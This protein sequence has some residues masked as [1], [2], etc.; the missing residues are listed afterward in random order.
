MFEHH[1]AVMLLIN[2]ETGHI[3]KANKSAANYYGYSIQEFEEMEIGKINQLQP[4]CIRQTI[5]QMMTEECREFSFQHRLKNGEIRYV[6]VHSSPIIFK[7]K[8]LLFS[9]IHDITDRKRAEEA[10]LNSERH[11]NRII[12]CV[13]VML[14]DYILYPDGS[15]RFLY[16]GPSCREILELDEKE[17]L[18]DMNLFWKM[19]HSD[20][21][22]RL[23]DEDAASNRE[24]KFFDT[25]VRILTQSGCFKWIQLS[26]RPNPAP[27]GEPAIWSGFILDVTERRRM[28]E[29]LKEAK[30]AAES[31][32]RAKSEF[33]ANMSHEIRTPMNVIIGM[34]RLIRETTLT[35]EQQEYALILSHSSEIL[36]SLIEDILDFS[37]IEAGKIELESVDFDLKNFLGKI[38]DILKIKASEKGLTLSCNISP[39]IPRFLKGDRN[40]LRQVILNLL[41]NSVKF[42]AKGGITITVENENTNEQNQIILSFSVADTGIGIPQDRLD[43]MFQPF[44]QADSSTTRKYGGTGL[45][46][47]IS[48]RLVELMGGRIL[49][50]SEYGKGTT[51]RFT[52]KFEQGSKTLDPVCTLNNTTLISDSQFAGLRVLLA[53]DN[54]FNQRF[55]LIILKKMGICADAVR[56]GKKAT[57]AIRQNEYDIILMDVQMPEMDGLE[58]TRIIRGEQFKVPIIAMTANATPQDREECIAAGMDDYISKPVEPEKLREVLYRYSGIMSQSSDTYITPPHADLRKIFDREEFLNRV[59]GDEE[60]MSQ[61]FSFLR[62]DLPDYIQILKTAVDNDDIQEVMRQ[63]HTIKGLAANLAA[64][65]LNDAAYQIEITAKSGEMEKVRL[66]MRDIEQECEALLS[67]I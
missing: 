38:T 22:R 10:L 9:I 42:T 34:S 13:P 24:G 12:S 60:V 36:L 7:G 14:Y 20:D 23:H 65:R 55:G 15:S 46:L 67:V 3:I 25:E 58:A 8:T 26:S 2:P 31:A 52:A 27:P 30:E 40:R 61:L 33:L 18:S 39:D 48:K 37:K 35:D 19:I 53:E 41:N 47:V 4:E 29:E 63:S 21:L 66:L 16:V 1:S 50:E 64:H 56:N 44:S 6:E 32:N 59:E 11:Y 45:G 28:I 49:I 51:F 54:E 57:E 5:T 43:R 62:K 17:L